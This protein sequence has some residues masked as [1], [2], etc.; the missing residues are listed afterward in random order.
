[1][2]KFSESNTKTK[3]NIQ[4]NSINYISAGQ[5]QKY[6][7]VVGKYL[8]DDCKYIIKYLI[9]HN[10][11]YVNDLSNKS[12][13]T[14]NALEDFYNRGVP[15]DE[16]LKQLYKSIGVIKNSHRLL[17]IPVFQTYEQFNGIITKKTALDNVV[18]DLETERGRNNVVKQYTP[19]VWKIVRQYAGKSN[20][21]VDEL[22]SAALEGLTWAMNEYGKRTPKRNTDEKL[23]EVVNAQTFGQYA[24]WR[25]V[26]SILGNIENVSRVV[27]VPKSQQQAEREKT[28]SN[29][30]SNSISG[31]NIISNGK[32][33]KSS[34]S[35]T[36]F[37]LVGG[38]E[39][40]GKN[41]DQEDLDKLWKRVYQKLEQQFDKKTLDIY[42][43][44]YGINGHEKMKSKDIAAK[45]GVVPS[46]ISYYTGK[47]YNFM[48]QDKEMF[49]MLT[50]IFELMKECQN[51]KDREYDFTEPITLDT[52]L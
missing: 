45:Y 47:I 24:A 14:G 37:D 1:M 20:L 7:D 4:E 31:D 33:E 26:H 5:L 11:T 49:G 36:Y 40:A 48:R 29:T 42:Y 21:E 51:D 3:L 22:Y 27:R 39:N 8:S 43:D 9:E 44:V 12:N 50:D 34:N 15:S 35:K 25:M 23:Q 10:D 16:S 13:G 38:Y 17:E 41:L 2:R 18:L 46:A 28:G 52:I 32:G 30:K 19:I 6:L